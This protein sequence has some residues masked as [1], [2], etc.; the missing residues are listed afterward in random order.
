MLLEIEIPRKY[1]WAR[2]SGFDA[3]STYLHRNAEIIKLFLD[4]AKEARIMSR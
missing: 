1:D 4:F 2:G 3:L